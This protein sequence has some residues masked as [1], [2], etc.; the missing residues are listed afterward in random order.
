MIYLSVQDYLPEGYQK[1]K[2]PD[3]R[4]NGY[5][6][7]KYQ[8]LLLN[9]FNNEL[10]GKAYVEYPLK[11]ISSV[12]FLP[13]ETSP[14]NTDKNSACV[15]LLAN[16]LELS[17]DS[18]TNSSFDEDDVTSS[19]PEIEEPLLGQVPDFKDAP[20]P[21]LE[22]TRMDELDVNLGIDR[23]KQ[24]P[25][26]IKIDSNH[27][28]QC[29]NVDNYDLIKSRTGFSSSYTS[30]KRGDVSNDLNVPVPEV[31][32]LDSDQSNNEVEEI[33]IVY[34]SIE[35]VGI[36]LMYFIKLFPCSV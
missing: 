4:M 31:I 24:V 3:Q 34:N 25:E 32:M 20:L 1:T 22:S 15:D 30:L 6:T 23:T 16:D 10:V 14:L 13:S 19:K 27:E 11:D 2:F 5:E 7:H 26:V 9:K 18:S 8:Y 21:L 35:N 28:I 36:L 33:E 29:Y 12:N 17:E